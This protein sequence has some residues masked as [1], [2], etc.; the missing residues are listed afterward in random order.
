METK[1]ESLALNRDKTNHSKP[2]DTHSFSPDGYYQL[3][4]AHVNSQFRNLHAHQEKLALL[5]SF[6]SKVPGV[7]I[8]RIAPDGTI[9]SWNDASYDLYGHRPDSV[10]GKRFSDLLLETSSSEEFNNAL[11]KTWQSGQT[12]ALSCWL[13]Q[14]VTGENR[15]VHGGFLTHTTVGL[16]KDIF[17]IQI[18]ATAHH[19]AEVLLI[20]YKDD[21]AL[22][23]KE[24]TEAL[25]ITNQKL[26]QEVEMR[27]TAEKALRKSKENLEQVVQQ[28]TAR[29]NETM[30]ELAH[31]HKELVEYKNNLEALNQELL[32]TNKAV[33]VLARNIEKK[34]EAY[35]EKTAGIVMDKIMPVLKYLIQEEKKPSRQADLQVISTLLVEISTMA[36]SSRDIIADLSPSEMKVAEMIKSGFSSDQIAQQLH[37]SISTIKSHRKNIR[38]KLNINKRKVNLENFLLQKLPPNS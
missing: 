13:L 11:Q 34:K 20:Q 30:T 35:Q 24:R 1:S 3:I 38:K 9:L 18:D 2:F 6:A 33:T 26:Q 15:W 25:H 12:S 4:Q 21:L 36:N 32:E 7:A 19:Q 8:Q 29:L 5:E 22:R 16:P 31:K 17:T 37:L 28:R 23:V 10:L 14:S 27:E